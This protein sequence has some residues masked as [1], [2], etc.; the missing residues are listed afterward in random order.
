[1]PDGI[2]I[3]VILVIFT[4]VVIIY[5]HH[6]ILNVYNIF[7]VLRWGTEHESRVVEEYAMMMESHH[8]HCPSSPVPVCR[9]L[10]C[11]SPKWA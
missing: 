6:L 10:H 7:S 2:N 4:V 9:H 3:T 8:T 11:S 1:M 5:Y